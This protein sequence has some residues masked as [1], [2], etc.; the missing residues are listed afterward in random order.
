MS[1]RCPCGSGL[2]FKKCCRR[3]ILGKAS[4]ATPLEL[5]RSRYSAYATGAVEY[6]IKTTL[7]AKR[8]TLDA[9]EL[10]AWCDQ[11]EWSGLEIL[12]FGIEAENP[13]AGFVEFVASYETGGQLLRHHEYST[14]VRVD[15]RWYYDEGRFEDEDP[16]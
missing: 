4:A 13:D 6:L 1:E 10:K 15:Y 2:V 16:A 3:F 11:T 14:F 5:M 12:R 8:D 7:P 9:A